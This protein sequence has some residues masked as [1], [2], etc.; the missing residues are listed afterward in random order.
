MGW[1]IAFPLVY[2][3]D[4]I[5]VKAAM[6]VTT[7]EILSAIAPPAAASGV[8]VI[9]LLS[10]N[11]LTGSSDDPLASLA[12]QMPLGVITYVLVLRTV[13]RRNVSEAIDFLCQMGGLSK[14]PKLLEWL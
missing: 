13:G 8:M 10:L 1:A 11:M 14:R 12:I 5:L 4:M 9:V 2:L 6:R 7:E 3:F